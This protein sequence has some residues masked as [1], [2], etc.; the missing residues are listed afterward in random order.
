MRGRAV[1][2]DLERELAGAPSPESVV[3]H[4]Q[5]IATRLVRRAQHAHDILAVAVS[6]AETR[7]SIVPGPSVARTAGSSPS[8]QPVTVGSG[9]MALD[10]MDGAPISRRGTPA[11]AQ[12]QPAS[13]EERQPRV[14]VV[15]ENARVLSTVVE[16]IGAEF[17]V[18]TAISGQQALSMI[19]SAMFD[20]V[21]VKEDLSDCSGPTVLKAAVSRHPMTAGV[22]LSTRDRY[23]DSMRA[24]RAAS[25]VP[26][27]LSEPID[28]AELLSKARGI[29][30]LVRMRQA[31][32]KL[33]TRQ[34]G[35]E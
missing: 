34:T 14:L 6:F 16:V 28:P 32:A 26:R 18:R 3:A 24:L 30:T 10:A 35:E 9:A 21:I 4:E 12:E 25:I 2:A 23:Q 1:A 27:V 22:L 20:L 11:A 8:M 17:E 33:H 19:G 7:E 5:V 29:L 13:S 15:H 31:T